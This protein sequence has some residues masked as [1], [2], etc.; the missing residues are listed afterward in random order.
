MDAD[1]IAAELK[2]PEVARR[3]AAAE[4]LLHEG[5]G[6]A[7]IPLV[8]ACEDAD[9]QVREAANA[10]LEGLGP[11]PR[12]VGPQLA[13]ALQ[14]PGLAGYWAATLLG[15]LGTAA[16]PWSRALGVAV[17]ENRDSSVRQRAAWA[18]GKIGPQAI[19]ASAALEAAS[20][21]ADARLA[22]LATKALQT[23]G[24]AR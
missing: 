13:T 23:I 18:L 7:V 17:A 15:R 5:G 10:A 4:S 19:E 24:R 12:E 22:R 16:S 6:L 3:R 2:S 14:R 21:D 11:P 1:S 8:M 20:R 9:E